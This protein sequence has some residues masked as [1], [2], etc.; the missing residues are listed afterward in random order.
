[1][2]MVMMM[3][4]YEQLNNYYPSKL[5]T[6][7]QSTNKMDGQLISYQPSK[8]SIFKK[9]TK[10]PAMTSSR[11]VICGDQM[12]VSITLNFK[13]KHNPKHSICHHH[14]VFSIVYQKCLGPIWTPSDGPM[15][16]SHATNAV[17]QQF[18]ALFSHFQRCEISGLALAANQFL[19]MNE[20]NGTE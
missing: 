20:W 9:S 13:P 5:S 3:M 8:L 15:V 17:F 19:V 7:N 12:A 1:M 6:V 11:L 10:W 18:L 4:N 14:S 2:I 16:R